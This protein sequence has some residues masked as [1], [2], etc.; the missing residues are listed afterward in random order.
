MGV[1]REDDEARGVVG[2]SSTFSARIFQ[3]VDLGRKARGERRP[4]RILELRDLRDCRACARHVGL[5]PERADDL[6]ALPERM[7]VA[8]DRPDRA[9]IGLGRLAEL[10]VDREEVFAHDMETRGREEMVDV[11][12][13]P[14]WSSRSGS[15]RV[16][17]AVLHGRKGVLEGRTRQRLPVGMHL[18]SRDMGV[19]SR[20]PWDG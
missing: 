4:R 17:P 2:S 5:E 9:E 10:E 12:H 16:R 19:R 8:V 3:A 20:L 6:A 14:R 15:C 7:N 18:L 1:L 11:R 13:G